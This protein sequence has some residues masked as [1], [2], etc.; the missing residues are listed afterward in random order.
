MDFAPGEIVV[1]VDASTDP[2]MQPDQ[3]AACSF[4]REGACYKIRDIILVCCPF[5]GRGPALVFHGE[6]D[7]YAPSGAREGWNPRRFRKI[8]PPEP[9]EAEFTALLKR[10]IRQPE[11]V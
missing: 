3:I 1:C 2:L 10:P 8:D 5:N 7:A 9:C 11:R 6:P 4:L